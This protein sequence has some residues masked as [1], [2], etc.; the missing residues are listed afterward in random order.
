[1]T[2]IFNKIKTGLIT[3]CI[4]LIS[5]QIY[6]Q[7]DTN[8]WK[9][10][11]AFGFNKPLSSEQNE[12]YSS[13]NVNF[14]TINLGVQHMFSRSLG[15]KLDF[16]Y[17]RSSNDDN[18]PEFKLNY[19]RVNAQLVYDLTNDLSFM[20]PQGF[21]LVSHLGPG[22]SFTKP[23]ANYAEN[24]HTFLNGMAGLELHYGISETLSVYGDVSYVLALSQ[25]DKY[26]P[27]VDGFSFNGNLLTATLGVSVSLSG[28]RYCD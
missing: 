9:M 2:I 19:S 3:T 27:A 17:N 21:A 14:P 4:M 28:C 15:A 22:M 10:H 6:A 16:G 23:L 24:K 8:E 12:G 26:N 20:I 13:K 1:M 7:A 25:K 5:L 18:S 11:L